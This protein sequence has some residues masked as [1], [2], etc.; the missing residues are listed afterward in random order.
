LFRRN[1]VEQE[2]DDE[3]QFHLDRRVEVLVEN[4][5]PPEE[6]RREAFRAMEGLTQRKEEC[7]DMDRTR[8]LEVVW[9]DV[10]Y[11]LRSLKSSPLF[12]LVAISSLAL[13]IGANTAI[14]T[15]MH[16]ILWK[17]L[18]VREPG[19]LVQLMRMS[20]TDS[21]DG[22]SWPWFQALSESGPP[23]G[24]LIAKA[25]ASRK[26]FG[27]NVD[28][29]ERVI[30]EPV[31]ANYF[32][33]LRVASFRGRV[34][35]PADDHVLG[36]NAVAVLSH[37]FWV[38]R[39]QS[40]PS[41]L[42]K[43]IYYDETPYVVAGVAEPGF[44]GVQPGIAVDVW[45]PVTAAFPGAALQAKTQSI[46][47]IFARLN[48]RADARAAQSA[49][50][51]RFRELIARD[52]LP[53]Y[54]PQ[55]RW[56]PASAHIVVRPAR[57]GLAGFFQQYRR[58]MFLLMGIVALVLLIS[59]ANLA[60][61]TLARNVARQR[62]IDVRLALGASRGRVVS[63]LLM[64]S[65]LIAFLGAAAGVALATGAAKLL[66]AMLPRLGAP[67]NLDSSP[68]AT[69][70]GFTIAVAGIT[71]ILFGLLP[72]LRASHTEADAKLKS[73]ARVT[74]GSF[75]G[76][77]LVTGQL[78]LSL[79]LLVAAGLFLGT[80]RNLKATDLGFRPERVTVFDVSF[81]RGTDS[82][83]IPQAYARILEHFK[84]A[85]GVIA[86]SHVWPS[87]FSRG[88]WQRG[89][90]VEGR[91]FFANQRDFACGVSVGPE[92]FETLGMSL[93][94]GRHLDTRDQMSDTPA[95]VVN[96]SFASA[97]FAGVSPLGRHVVVDGAP[98][99]N[100]EVVGVV[101]DAKH[102]GVRENVCRTTYV[103]AGQA[104]QWN[105]YTAQGL[106]SFLIRTSADLPSTAE[107][108]RA[109]IASAG[110]GVQ[111]ETLQ[112]LETAVDDMVNQEHMLAVLS[113]VF[114]A[115]AL[116]L[117]GIGLY[118]VMAY[119]V[120][121]RTGELGIRMALGAT[122]GGVQ[123]LVLKQTAQLILIGV[124][125]GI[126]AAL[127]LARLT[128]SLLYGVKPGDEMIFAASALVLM[129]AGAFAGYIP[130]VRASHV[131]PIVA[132]RHE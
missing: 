86:V 35:E 30:G 61:L 120:S 66:V 55:D 39:F 53:R 105:A 59:C 122:P 84:N 38:A 107:R 116:V 51:G 43:T 48:A 24:E 118:G 101:R 80:I 3:L 87:V 67:L 31:S 94:A 102:Y 106:G 15:L 76:R 57:S 52:L 96:E 64:E 104:P 4:G 44:S 129:A 112:P 83:Q 54:P 93:V 132:L 72:A 117:A 68:D 75:V 71:A 127:P 103:P 79:I 115:L 65:L 113:T 73:G 16:A 26:K 1:R 77:A 21:D 33:A 78:A 69:V 74:G 130:A 28:S 27:T 91:P 14:F 47:K 111:M 12:T 100:W 121:R 9:R 95:M 109:A 6:A 36:G 50:N 40:D 19:E 2:L 124:G 123:W 126:A 10:R 70:L 11:G 98:L 20:S 62:E 49:W 99:Q 5:V 128:S 42:G 22:Y 8:H 92:F 25:T 88:R 56:R 108:I 97:Y 41:I 63:Q 37:Q 60:N 131:D 45:V 13:G 58:P 17:P 34:L 18:P 119:G 90:K 82:R 46:L 81:P 29:T 32:R 110:G 125:V 89:V 23:F 85:P 7:R 114:A